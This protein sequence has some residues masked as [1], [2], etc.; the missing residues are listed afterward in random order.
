MNL[1]ERPESPDGTDEVGGGSPE[2]VGQALQRLD[3]MMA[4]YLS[5]AER[6]KLKL[7]L[8]SLPDPHH[9]RRG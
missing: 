3:G 5:E 4:G 2:E 6:E 1:P 7:L 9:E 8:T